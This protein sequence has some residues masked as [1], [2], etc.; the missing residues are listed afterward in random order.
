MST[1]LQSLVQ[2][3]AQRCNW[4]ATA[5]PST[6]TTAAVT[7]NQASSFFDEADPDALYKDV[8]LKVEAD[9]ASAPLN[10]GEVRRFPTFSGTAGVFTLPTGRTYTNT[11]TTTMTFGFYKTV[12]PAQWA[13]RQGW[14]EY[15][16][17]VLSNISYRRWGLLTLVVDGDMESSATTSW[18]ASNATH[19]KV[20]T[21]GYVSAGLRAS[22]VANTSANG[23]IKSTAIPVAANDVYAV[24]ADLRCASGTGHLQAY[25]ETNAAEIDSENTDLQ[26]WRY[27]DFTFTIPSGCKSITIRLKGAE[28]SADAYWDNVSLRNVNAWRFALP[29]WITSPRD[30]EGVHEYIGNSASGNAWAVSSQIMRE[31]DRPEILEDVIGGSWYAELAE[32]PMDGSLLF[33]KGLSAY[34][35]LTSDSDTTQADTKLVCSGARYYAHLDLDQAAKARTALLEFNLRAR[36]LPRAIRL[37]K[38]L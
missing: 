15:V 22:R 3:C 18:T 38:G 17:R 12:P 14:K 24:R 10:V 29:S 23:Y 32:Q 27:L 13:E 19:T 1:T 6:A 4:W 26:D 5:S 34:S 25:D 20:T 2:A 16:N 7:F 28:A 36:Q 33:V 8:W 31:T 37:L 9:S 21:S 11:P 35:E 30:L